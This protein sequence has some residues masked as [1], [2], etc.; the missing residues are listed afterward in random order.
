MVRN[1]KYILRFA[2]YIITLAIFIAITN[3]YCIAQKHPVTPLRPCFLWYSANAPARQ[4]I[5]QLLGL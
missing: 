2:N 3:E 1:H 4:I 5:T